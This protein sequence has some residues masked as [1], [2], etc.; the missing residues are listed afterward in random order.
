VAS[1][2]DTVL[3]KLEWVRAGGEVSDRQWADIVGVLKA[4]ETALDKAYLEHWALALSVPDIL[5]RARAE[6]DAA[7]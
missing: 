7:S 4:A 6:A 1:A 3:A 2:E 5:A